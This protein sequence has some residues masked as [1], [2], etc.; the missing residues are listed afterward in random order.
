MENMPLVD[1]T[2]IGQGRKYERGPNRERSREHGRRTEA[3][4]H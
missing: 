1:V 2:E 3:M 4:S